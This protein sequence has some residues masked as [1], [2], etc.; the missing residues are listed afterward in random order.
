MVQNPSKEC[1]FQKCSGFLKWFLSMSNLAFLLL[2][3]MNDLQLVVNL[4]DLL[5]WSLLLTGDFDNV[6]H[7]SWRVFF[8][9]LNVVKGFVFTID[10]ILQ[11]SSSVVW[12]HP[13][14]FMLLSSTVCYFLLINPTTVHVISL[15][16]LFFK[17]NDVM[18]YLHGVLLWPLIVDSQQQLLTA[19]NTL[20]TFYLFSW[21]R[22]NEGIAHT[23]PENSFWVNCPIVFGPY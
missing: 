4:L 12:G 7:I 2:R 1:F 18:F 19:S 14:L 13:G 9:W 15:L 11:W 16:H 8:T 10:R 5:L 3:L 21:W 20:Q 17:P 22:N 6:T 23:C